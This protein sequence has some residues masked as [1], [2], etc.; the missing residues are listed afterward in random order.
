MIISFFF[1]MIPHLLFSPISSSCVCLM[2]IMCNG[3]TPN[4][5][6][7]ITSTRSVLFLLVTV[8]NYYHCCVCVLY[9]EFSVACIPCGGAPGE[10]TKGESV[11]NRFSTAPALLQFPAEPADQRVSEE[12]GKSGIQPDRAQSSKHSTSAH[13]AST[14]TNSAGSSLLFHSL[15]SLS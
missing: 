5:C 9:T 13:T 7:C 15:G 1:L 14:G 8:A 3:F 10:P 2:Y 11:L 12:W 6:L 4:I